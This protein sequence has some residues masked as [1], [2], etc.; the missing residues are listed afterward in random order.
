[1]ANWASNI[2]GVLALYPA[3]QASVD[4]GIGLGVNDIYYS[5]PDETAWKTNYL[6]IIDA[7]T[8]KWPSARVFLAY[9]WAQG[10]GTESATAHG[11]IDDIIAARPGVA[12]AGPDEA[13]WIEGGDD[14]ATNTTDGIHLSA[15]GQTAAEAVWLSAMGY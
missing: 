14:G 4:I 12:F 10:K 13:V 11:W 15:T 7:I 6:S 3:Q 1:M 9:P 5:M 2:A 8:A